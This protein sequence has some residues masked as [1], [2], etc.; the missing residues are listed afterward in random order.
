M[1]AFR[2]SQFYS[3]DPIAKKEKEN[4]ERRIKELLV[5]L[6]SERD[7][8]LKQETIVELQNALNHILRVKEPAKTSY[9]DSVRGFFGTIHGPMKKVLDDLWHNYKLN[10]KR[11]AKARAAGNYPS[12]APQHPGNRPPPPHST[13]HPP[14]S[15]YPGNFP[16]APAASSSHYML[17]QSEGHRR[18]SYQSGG[19]RTSTSQDPSYS[20]SRIPSRAT[21]YTPPQPQSDHSSN[22]H[23]LRE[24]QISRSSG[25]GNAGYVASQYIGGPGPY[26]ASYNAGPSSGPPQY[27][28]NSISP[29]AEAQID[30]D[31]ATG[32]LWSWDNHGNRIYAMQFEGP[33]N[34]S[35][36]SIA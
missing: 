23:W 10:S 6:Q 7:E 9:K 34:I 33:W 19:I 21:Y 28:Q 2:A 29:S 25:G 15:S 8:A 32:L 1:S 30:E 11:L 13:S 24:S 18:G 17:N 4:F 20:G 36:P 12:Q 5:K 16:P 3:N 22:S 31:P 14:A 27:A 26:P 35:P